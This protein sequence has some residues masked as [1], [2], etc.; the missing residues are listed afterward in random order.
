MSIGTGE[1]YAVANL[2]VH[3]RGPL[4]RGTFCVPAERLAP[5]SMELEMQPRYS[6]CPWHG[7]SFDVRTGRA[8]GLRSYRVRTYPT[9]VEKGRVR[10]RA[11]PLGERCRQ[12]RRKPPS[13][14]PTIVDVARAA[15]VSK[16]TVSN[17]IRSVSRV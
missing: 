12:V 5:G 2:C 3:Q 8:M 10:R 4:C 14:S 11:P 15:G 1:V 13:R 6:A 7:W 16:S 9:R 17:V